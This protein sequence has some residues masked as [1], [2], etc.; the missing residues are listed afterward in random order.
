MKLIAGVI[1][2]RDFDRNKI[3]LR[4]LKYYL[5]DPYYTGPKLTPATSTPALVGVIFQM[6][7]VKLS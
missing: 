7:R 5:V 6:F 4:L 2:L 3:S 1:L